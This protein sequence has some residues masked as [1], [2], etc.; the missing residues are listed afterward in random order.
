[1]TDR[2]TVPYLIE[3][4]QRGEK[5]TMLTAYDYPTARALDEAGID[6]LLIGDSV[7]MV[8]LGYDSTLPVTVD[9]ILHHTRPVVRAAERAMVISDMPFLSF[10]IS[11]EE[12][13]RNAGRMVQEGGAHAVKVEG[14]LKV[15]A[16]V[17]RIVDMGIPVMGHLGLT[18]QSVH[19]FGGYSLQANT[20]EE[21]QRLIDDAKALED[22]GCFAIVLEKVP[23]QLAKI[24]T[25]RLSIAII[26]IGAG[27]D[28][29]G[30]VLVVQ[31]LLGLYEKFVPKFSKQ[32]AQLGHEIRKATRKYIDEVKAGAFPSADHSYTADSKVIKA[33]K[34]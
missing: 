9:D 17:K 20:V 24:V 22:A 29:D 28:C 8:V 11:D 5:L 27:P 23:A 3:R 18:P 30:Q 32:Y 33:L 6:I 13:M 7:G 2:V 15:A 12:A 4:K 16:T 25:E 34:K 14:G 31:D 26:G 19:Q 21:A 10:Q 1:M